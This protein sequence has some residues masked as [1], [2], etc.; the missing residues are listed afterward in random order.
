MAALRAL[1][2]LTA[3]Y[4]VTDDLVWDLISQIEGALIQ[5][6]LRTVEA[7]TKQAVSMLPEDSVHHVEG[8]RDLVGHDVE[9]EGTNYRCISVDPHNTAQV[10]LQRRLAPSDS[11]KYRVHWGLCSIIESHLPAD[12]RCPT[13]KTPTGT[14][15]GGLVTC[16]NGHE[17]H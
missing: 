11:P 10:I 12:W 16:A 4:P 6:D 9:C 17:S 13:C 8:P 3:K 5:D 15:R 7:F 1:H 14:P 2:E